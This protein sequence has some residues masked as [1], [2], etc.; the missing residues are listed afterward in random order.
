MAWSRVTT[1]PF[2]GEY[3]DRI[4]GGGS[5][6][7]ADLASVGIMFFDAWCRDDILRAR[8]AHF[9][10]VGATRGVGFGVQGVPRVLDTVALE[11]PQ[12]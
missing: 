7:R 4:H 12:V 3:R 1:G 6:A 9:A 10:A 8:N 5:T 2:V 11:N